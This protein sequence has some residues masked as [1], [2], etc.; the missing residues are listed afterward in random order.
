MYSFI[1]QRNKQKEKKIVRSCMEAKR[2]RA[3]RNGRRKRNRK[4]KSSGR[5]TNNYQSIFV[6]GGIM[7]DKNTAKVGDKIVKIPNNAKRIRVEKDKVIID[8]KVIYSIESPPNLE[9]SIET[10]NEKMNEDAQLF[11]ERNIRDESHEMS[12]SQMDSDLELAINLSLIEYEKES[13][14]RGQFTSGDIQNVSD[15]CQRTPSIDLS[16]CEDDDDVT[17]ICDDNEDSLIFCEEENK[18]KSAKKRQRPKKNS[19]VSSKTTSR[20]NKS[21]KRKTNEKYQKD[22]SKRD[23]GECVICKEEERCILYVECGH[24]V[25]CEPC[26]LQLDARDITKCPCCRKSGTKTKLYIPS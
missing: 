19:E 24:L 5:G 10:Q 12:S 22:S 20:S 1:V 13:K 6:S 18:E 26:S 4:K 7:I 15:I 14:K 17:V 25:L 3:K 2:P 8:G 23:L 16:Y 11:E 9:T 21:K